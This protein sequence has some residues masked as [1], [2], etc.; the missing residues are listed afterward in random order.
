MQILLYGKVEKQSWS[1]DKL[2]KSRFVW[3]K[4]PSFKGRPCV[5]HRVEKE[6]LKPKPHDKRKPETC[7]QKISQHRI[8]IPPSPQIPV[9]YP[10]ACKSINK[11]GY[12]SGCYEV[13]PQDKG[14]GEPRNE[15]GKRNPLEVFSEDKN[16]ELSFFFCVV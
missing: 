6:K 16:P 7:P 4:E 11:G 2:C 10:Y 13:K 14:E 15:V 9:D 12:E 5:G 3:S 8:E 1:V